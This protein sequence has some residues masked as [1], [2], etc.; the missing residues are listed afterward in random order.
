MKF[1]VYLL[2]CNVRVPNFGRVPNSG[3]LYRYFK[4]LDFSINTQL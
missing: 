2:M 3:Q 1:V 4:L